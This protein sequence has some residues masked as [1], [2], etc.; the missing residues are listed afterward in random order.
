[1]EAKADTMEPG[2]GKMEHM[3]TTTEPG[4][5]PIKSGP[6]NMDLR[7]LKMEL[8]RRRVARWLAWETSKRPLF[9]RHGVLFEYPRAPCWRPGQPLCRLGAAM[10]RLVQGF[11]CFLTVR[12]IA[13]WGGRRVAECVVEL[14]CGPFNEFPVN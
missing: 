10:P 2:D 3:A 13:H 5:P 1:M 8:L 12:K 14:A 6:P 7:T 9:W 4:V 11:I